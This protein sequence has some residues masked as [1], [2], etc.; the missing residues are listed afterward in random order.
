[1]LCNFSADTSAHTDNFKLSAVSTNKLGI[2]WRY[3]IDTDNI[4]IISPVS[5]DFFNHAPAP[6]FLPLLL[7]HGSNWDS[8]ILH[9]D[10]V[11]Y[12]VDLVK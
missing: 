8:F 12:I 10:I 9:V 1:M 3:G 4:Q 7:H 5:A 11:Y 6:F 2:N